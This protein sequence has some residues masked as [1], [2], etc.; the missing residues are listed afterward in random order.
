M[1][2][3]MSAQKEMRHPFSSLITEEIEWAVRHKLM[4]IDYLEKSV[5]GKLKD[6]VEKAVLADRLSGGCME[7]IQHI[8]VEAILLMKL[9][10]EKFLAWLSME[11][12]TYEE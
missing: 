2:D 5:C 11:R 10:Q 4:S 9:D 6:E 3:V 7:K 8:I 1:K 12:N